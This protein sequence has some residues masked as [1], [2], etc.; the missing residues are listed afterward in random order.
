MD[1]LKGFVDLPG[2]GD[3]PYGEKFYDRVSRDALA[4][5]DKEKTLILIAVTGYEEI[6]NQIRQNPGLSSF[7]AVPSIFLESLYEDMLLLSADKV[8][9]LHKL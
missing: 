3:V 6:M 1:N 5:M 7:E 8:A 2:T 9:E 4:M